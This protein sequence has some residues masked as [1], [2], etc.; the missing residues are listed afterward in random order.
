MSLIF[1]PQDSSS[2]DAE[3]DSHNREGLEYNSADKKGPPADRSQ[4]TE[5]HSQQIR[6]Y[7]TYS[8]P[9]R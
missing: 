6:Q 8:D 1:T 5:R 7:A 9:L 2:P 4:A 3:D